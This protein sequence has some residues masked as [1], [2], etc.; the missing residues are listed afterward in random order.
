M[1]KGVKATQEEG[2]SSSLFADRA[3]VTGQANGLDTSALDA[4]LLFE[5]VQI[6][7]QRKASIQIG[8]TQDG[9]AWAIQYWDGKFPLKEYFRSTEELNRSWA[10]LIRAAYGK[11]I[12]PEWDEIVRSYGW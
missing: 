6:L 7:A 2:L 12:S 3:R 9:T 4:S 10:A 5:V 11:N 1:P 8:V